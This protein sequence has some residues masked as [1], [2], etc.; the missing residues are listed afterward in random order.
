MIIQYVN[1]PELSGWRGKAARLGKDGWRVLLGSADAKSKVS[2]SDPHINNFMLVCETIQDILNCPRRQ[3][4]Q[5]LCSQVDIPSKLWSCWGT[6]DHVVH[7]TKILEVINAIV[8]ENRTLIK[9]I[10][11]DNESQKS[12]LEELI[13]CIEQNSGGSP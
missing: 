7:K 4:Y 8:I 10:C 3:H 9:A 11:K 6:Y 5:S 1:M 2:E 13:K 12:I